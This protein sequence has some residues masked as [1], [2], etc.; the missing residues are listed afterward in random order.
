M[1]VTGLEVNGPDILVSLNSPN[2]VTGSGGGE[3][4]S[5]AFDDEDEALGG[6]AFRCLRFPMAATAPRRI[7]P[8]SRALSGRATFESARKTAR[9]GV[10]GTM[11]EAQ[12]VG[13]FFFLGGV[14]FFEKKE[15]REKVDLEEVKGI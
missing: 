7:D 6:K 14:F 9:R 8:W 2:L 13:W 15:R 5:W 1:V 3:G 10:G 12:V 4:A 11:V